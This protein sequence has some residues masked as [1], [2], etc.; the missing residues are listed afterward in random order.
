MTEKSISGEARPSSAAT[1]EGASPAARPLDAKVWRV[2]Y[3]IRRLSRADGRVLVQLKT[4]WRDGT[5]HFLF[6]SIEFLGEARRPHSPPCGEPRG[7]QHG[8]ALMIRAIEVVL[9]L[10]LLGR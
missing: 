1:Q 7:A 10:A 6:E 9:P 5:S 3:M 4:V 2:W 8:S